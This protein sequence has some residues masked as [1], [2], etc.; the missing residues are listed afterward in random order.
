MLPAEQIRVLVF[1]VLVATIYVAAGWML[2]R[3]ITA[4]LRHALPPLSRRA[5][6][7]R[8]AVYA[9]ALL[10]LACMA[11]GRFVEPWRLE[12]TRVVLTSPKLREATRPIRIVHLSDLH[13][14]PSTRLEERLPDLVAAEKPDL[15]AFTGD[16]VN[17]PAGLPIFRRCLSRIAAVA[18]TFAVEGNW[19]SRIWPGLERFPGT[20]ARELAGDAARLDIAGTTLWVAG[21]PVDGEHLAGRALEAVPRDAF[22]I[23]LYHI[24]DDRL[25][26]V[27]DRPVDL[28]LAGH[29]HGGQVALPLFGA[30]VTLAPQGKTYEAGLYRVRDTWLYVNRGIGMEGG[31]A[32]R[33]RFCARPELTVIDLVPEGA[34]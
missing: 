13:C 2:L 18:P 17:S 5:I 28:F 9:L 6:R 20:G 27:F 16:C 1:V 11:Y 33:V 22:A 30:L 14:D 8:R 21:V 23:F 19:D 15:I 32:P 10:G 25:P 24:P 29:T 34:R 12:V 7:A 26:A 4:R 3:Q 31:P